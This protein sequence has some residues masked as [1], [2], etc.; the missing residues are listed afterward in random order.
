MGGISCSTYSLP[1]D[2]C[3]PS[4]RRFKWQQLKAHWK[5]NSETPKSTSSFNDIISYYII[6]SLNI[7]Q[8]YQIAPPLSK[9]N[10]YMK[11]HQHAVL[12]SMNAPFEAAISGSFTSPAISR[13]EFR[14]PVV[15]DNQIIEP[16]FR[17]L[18]QR[19]QTL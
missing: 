3:S 13:G 2:C 7:C 15:R 10:I 12:G 4:P 1:C 5:S 19:L 9:Q 8:S 16:S 14:Y 6:S 18:P 17:V 11:V